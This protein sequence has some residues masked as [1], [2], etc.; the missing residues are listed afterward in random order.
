MDI[1]T[2]IGYVGDKALIGIEYDCQSQHFLIIRTQFRKSVLAIEENEVFQK[3]QDLQAYLSKWPTLPIVLRLKH[4]G[5]VEKWIATETEDK[6]KAALGVRVENPQDFMYEEITD[7]SGKSLL[8]LIRK[9]PYLKAM[10]ALGVHDNRLWGIYLSEASTC[11]LLPARAYYSH[12]QAIR[13]AGN[14][15][16]MWEGELKEEEKYQ[17][18]ITQEEL[19]EELGIDPKLI[20]LYAAVWVS[21][22][23]DKQKISGIPA[24]L[25]HRARQQKFHKLTKGFCIAIAIAACLLLLSI[26]ALS[27]FSYQEKE[28]RLVL[29]AESTTLDRIQSHKTRLREKTEFLSSRSEKSLAPS[30]IPWYIDQLAAIAPKELGFDR[31]LYKGK[32]KQLKKIN[33][34]LESRQFDLLIQGES[35]NTHA[36]TAFSLALAEKPWAREAEIFRSQYDYQSQRL[37]FILLVSLYDDQIH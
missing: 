2:R 29:Q 6:I 25:S 5:T 21:Y 36:L 10:D 27:W 37:Q 8:T 19:A 13:L 17:E 28:N 32:S 3:V 23:P 12:N 33:M 26:T 22:L 14:S 9:E 16:H 18:S 11:F 7:T 30:R 35:R 34:Q 4:A 31:I 20:N 1:L 24:L 15:F